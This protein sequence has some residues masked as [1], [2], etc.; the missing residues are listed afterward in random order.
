MT[1][2]IGR[3]LERFR[4]IVKGKIRG[5]MRKYISHGEM[6]GRKGKDTVSIPVPKMDLP[7]F[8]HGK[9][10]SGGVGQG[11]GEVGDPIGSGGDQSDGTGKGGSEEG[12]RSRNDS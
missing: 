8:R 6:I 4:Q 5:D 12:F 10:G 7:H 2:A 11:D 1:S 9:N 3:D